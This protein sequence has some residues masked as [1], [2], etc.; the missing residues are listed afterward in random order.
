MPKDMLKKEVGLYANYEGEDPLGELL[1]MLRSI[2]FDMDKYSILKKAIAQL[3][4]TRSDELAG[5][6]VEEL[7]AKL[8]RAESENETLKG[9]LREHFADG[10]LAK[11]VEESNKSW[12]EADSSVGHYDKLSKKSK[13]DRAQLNAKRNRLRALLSIMESE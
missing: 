10:E 5:P 11:A 8:V 2:A 9:L 4:A 12:L 3:A 7:K 6:D 13:D 1:A